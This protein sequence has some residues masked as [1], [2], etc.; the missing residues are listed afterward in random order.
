MSKDSI[1]E[2]RASKANLRRLLRPPLA[3][4][5]LH[6]LSWLTAALVT[7]LSSATEL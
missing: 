1:R 4:A 6:A 3:A 5:Q 2:Q 7:D